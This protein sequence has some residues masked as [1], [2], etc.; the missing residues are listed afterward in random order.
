MW[1]FETERFISHYV[2]N[3]ISEETITVF[4]QNVRL[5]SKPVDDIVRDHRAV[6]NDIIGFTET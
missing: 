1:T 4:V 6:N 5:L 2:K 3:T